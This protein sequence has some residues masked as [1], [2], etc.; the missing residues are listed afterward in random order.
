MRHAA[1]SGHHEHDGP[2]HAP[3]G[4]QRLELKHA[5]YKAS[6]LVVLASGMLMLGVASRSTSS[7]P[8]MDTDT[9]GSESPAARPLSTSGSEPVSA[10]VDSPPT[11]AEPPPPLPFNTLPPSPAGPV[12]SPS[13]ASPLTLLPLDSQQLMPDGL[14]ASALRCTRDGGVYT[15]GSCRTDGDC[16]PGRA[17]LPHRETRRFECLDSECEED[18][19]CFPASSAA[20]SAAEEPTRPSS[21]AACPK[22]SRTRASHVMPRPSHPRAPAGRG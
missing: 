1:C 5:R 11:R 8:P 10:L 20:P 9:P 21:A 4:H 16:P 13:E 22:A 7:A 14:P 19:H 6:L 15:C 2:A 17:C 12:S 18:V 3:W